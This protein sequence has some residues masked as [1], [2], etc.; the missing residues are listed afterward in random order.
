MVELVEALT[1]CVCVVCVWCVC[2]TQFSLPNDKL[3][4]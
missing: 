4:Q 1:V 3:C 2:F